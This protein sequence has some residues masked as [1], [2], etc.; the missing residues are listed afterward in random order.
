VL[1]TE[2]GTRKVELRLFFLESI[3]HKPDS[4]SK[5]SAS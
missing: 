5:E 3:Y 1:G 2:D 4:T